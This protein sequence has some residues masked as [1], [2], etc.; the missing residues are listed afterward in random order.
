MKG[1]LQ[2]TFGMNLAE[3]D[4]LQFPGCLTELAAGTFLLFNGNFS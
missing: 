2:T 3:E 4:R 1:A